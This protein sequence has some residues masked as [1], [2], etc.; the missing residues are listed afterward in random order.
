M[1]RLTG[2][3]L[4]LFLALLMTPVTFAQYGGDYGR[5]TSAGVI[6]ALRT[7]RFH[8]M[9]SALSGVMR[10]ALW[11][12]GHVVNCLEGARG[13]NYDS[14]NDNP[15]QGQG[16]GIIPDLES[17]RSS[18]GAARA[19]EKAREAD[20]LALETLKLTDLARVKAGSSKVADLLGEAISAVQ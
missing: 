11:H 8:A 18:V 20:S 15:C 14:K 2:A 6:D 3:V 19:L 13:K 4:V 7:A 5:E 1:K 9:N 17:A 16:S 10:E 12:L